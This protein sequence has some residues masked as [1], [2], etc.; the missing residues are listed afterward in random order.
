MIESGDFS[1][2]RS[3]TTL[4]IGQRIDRL[5]DLAGIPSTLRKFTEDRIFF[6][7][8]A[9]VQSWKL[10]DNALQRNYSGGTIEERR[11]RAGEV[12]KQFYTICLAK[13][14]YR[15]HMNPNEES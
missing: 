10:V 5:V 6:S 9:V 13:A 11:N 7:A 8:L 3:E 1:V 4:S 15:L 12:W 14:L 2:N